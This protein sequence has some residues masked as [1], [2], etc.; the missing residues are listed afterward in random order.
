MK[1]QKNSQL[2]DKYKQ[3]ITFFLIKHSNFITFKANTNKYSNQ[4]LLEIITL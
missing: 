1:I 4:D 2:F 3:R